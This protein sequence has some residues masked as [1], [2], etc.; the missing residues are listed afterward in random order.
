[1]KEKKESFMNINLN[2]MEFIKDLPD[3]KITEETF[4][5][6]RFE[7]YIQKTTWRRRNKELL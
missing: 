5:G 7:R 1:M 3:R 2:S 4:I 6:K